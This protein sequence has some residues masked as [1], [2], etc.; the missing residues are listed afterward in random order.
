MAAPLRVLVM[1]SIESACV[2]STKRQG[3]TACRILR[4][5]DGARQRVVVEIGR[6]DE[7]AHRRE[8]D[9]GKIVSADRCEIAPA[10]FHVQQVNVL[11][12]ARLRLQG[13]VASTV[14]HERGFAAQ[15]PGGVDAQAQLGQLR[16]LG[17]EC[18]RL[19]LV[20]A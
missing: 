16:G 18:L 9:H 1:A 12:A 20:P 8:P 19:G 13:G 5:G 2:C 10:A 14:Q 6:A 11:R 3:S 4:S 15:Q 7:R 17:G